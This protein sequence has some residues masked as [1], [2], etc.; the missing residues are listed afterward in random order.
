MNLVITD[1]IR[2]AVLSGFGNQ[3]YAIMNIHGIIC[4]A[5]SLP[6]LSDLC[7]SLFFDGIL[8]VMAAISRKICLIEVY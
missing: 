8:A 7:I 1:A 3:T 6:I 5:F 2:D 4:N